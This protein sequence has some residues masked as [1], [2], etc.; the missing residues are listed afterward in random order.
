MFDANYV[1]NNFWV[2]IFIMTGYTSFRQGSTGMYYAAMV[3]YSHL[4]M[5][6]ACL[7][8]ISVPSEEQ[9]MGASLKALKI[10]WVTANFM[11]PLNKHFYVFQKQTPKV[12]TKQ[13][14]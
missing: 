6:S 13:L 4:L 3:D 2:L 5:I 14:M 11:Q 12:K 1:V 10:C 7:V 9:L 8:E